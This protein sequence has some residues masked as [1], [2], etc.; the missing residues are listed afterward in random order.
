MSLADL[1]FG[2]R[3]SEPAAWEGMYDLTTRG[4]GAMWRL[5]AYREL[6]ARDALRKARAARWRRSW[7]FRTVARVRDW[8]ARRDRG[9]TGPS[10]AKP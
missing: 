4:D 6:E 8:L 7:R 1:L 10:G 3:A 5:R 2:G 9:R